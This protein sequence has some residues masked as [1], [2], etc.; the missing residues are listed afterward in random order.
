MPSSPSL[1][2]PP[3]TDSPAGAVRSLPRRLA[4]PAGDAVAFFILLLLFAEWLKLL[5]ALALAGF[6]P[7]VFGA[8]F[9]LGVFLAT[10]LLAL[11]A[12]LAAT[13]VLHRPR[14]ASPQLNSSTP[15]SR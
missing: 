7:G 11:A 3:L 8:L 13:A 5:A 12:S 1:A 10:T 2:N 14:P 6:H 4:Q 15:S 9:N